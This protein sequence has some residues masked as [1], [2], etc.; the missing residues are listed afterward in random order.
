MTR[1]KTNDRASSTAGPPV[2]N[3]FWY[4]TPAAVIFTVGIVWGLFALA[5]R[6]DWYAG[7]AY[8]A[9]LYLIHITTSAYL[10]FTN[11]DVLR[12]RTQYGEGTKSWDKVCLVAFGVTFLITLA[13]GALDG[14]RYQW[15]PMPSELWPVGTT[16]FIAS[17][18]LV[19]WSMRVNPY[20]EKTA[21]IQKDRDQ[22]VIT[23]GPYHYV[24]HPGYIGTIFGYALA[25]PI[26]LGSWWA[27][28]PAVL[29]G[30]SLIIRTALED[31]MLLDEL[32]GYAGYA[33][34]VRFRLVPYLW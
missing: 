27:L 6:W 28:L 20:F 31:R 21:R 7:W 15:A 3:V 9:V 22:K 10:W 8:L 11:P 13:V 16:L 1:F 2:R 26:M 33:E 34:R 17:H 14:G 30:L 25:P 18:G 24:R 29:V 23:V 19:T 4:I 32:D 5:G 12:W